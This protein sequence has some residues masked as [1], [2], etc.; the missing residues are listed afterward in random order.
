MTIAP[1]PGKKERKYLKLLLKLAVTAVCIS[2]VCYKIDFNHFAGLLH[3]VNPW[4]LLAALPGFVFS[5]LLAS[6]R[7]NIYFR[8]VGLLLSEW[9]N[10]K[11]YW[12][13]MFFNLFLPGAVSGDAYKVIRL[14]KTFGIPYKKTTAVILLDRFSGLAGLG[15]LTGM[16]W[17]MLFKHHP[18]NKWVITAMIV[19][20]PVFY[21]AVKWLFVY[22][23]PVF[24]ST[25]VWGILVQC[26]QVISFYCILQSIGIHPPVL[27]YLFIFLLS[28]VVAVLPFTIGGLGVREMVFLWGAQTFGLAND[29]AVLAGFLFYIIML[30]VSSF[31][32]YFIFAD[33]LKNSQL[34]HSQ[35]KNN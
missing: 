17:L 13:G 22:L 11:L 25:F 18:L 32:L 10:I 35:R 24:W 1:L 27:P 28:S 31:G 30:I 16:I 2:Y 14:T 12:L 34:Y 6:F 20:V 23:L 26:C 5:K 9:I 3:T 8:Q 33:P 29:A 15:L 7:L 21:F 19:L 4:W